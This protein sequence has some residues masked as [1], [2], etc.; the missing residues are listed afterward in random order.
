MKKKISG[1]AYVL[2]NNIDTDQIIPAQHL[3][4]SLSDPEESKN[5]GKFALSG[6][7]AEAAGLPQGNKPFVEDGYQSPYTIVIGGKNF[8]CGS[9]REHAP[10]C[11]EIAGV[12][13]VI[14]ESYARIFYRNSV[15]GGFFIP[16]ETKDPLT[17]KVQT[18]DELEIDLET[19]TLT[20]TTQNVTHP[21]QP[22]GDVI[23]I[24]EAGNIFEYARKS[25]LIQSN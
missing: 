23:D 21:L 18:G 25:G 16:L 4:Y 9:S 10:A 8:G 7:P 14:A 3:V 22:L 20:N 24:I 17:D 2:G 12:Q 13:A 5:Y 19:S 6:V 1:R 15:D 11:M